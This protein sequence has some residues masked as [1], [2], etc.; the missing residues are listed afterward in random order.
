MYPFGVYGGCCW[1]DWML[2]VLTP[3]DTGLRPSPD[4]PLGG[5]SRLPTLVKLDGG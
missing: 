2:P 3:D 5:V 4:R 1:F